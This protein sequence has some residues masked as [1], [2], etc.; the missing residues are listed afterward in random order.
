MHVGTYSKSVRY[1]GDEDKAAANL[2][3]HRVD[4]ADAVGVFDDEFAL[5][6][7]DLDAEGKERFVALGMD[8]VDRAVAVVYTY[9]G[10]IIRLISARKATKRER[11]QYAKARGENA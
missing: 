1:V 9:R 11:G 7:E 2:K 5:W 3:K 6:R 4:F 8:H 10:E